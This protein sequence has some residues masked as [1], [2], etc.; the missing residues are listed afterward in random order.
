MAHYGSGDDYFGGNFSHT[1]C[2]LSIGTTWEGCQKR[3]KSEFAVVQQD[4]RALVEALYDKAWQN[5]KTDPTV[6]ASRM[7]AGALKAL[8]VLPNA[9]LNGYRTT[10]PSWFLLPVFQV[11]CLLVF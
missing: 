6:I 9:I 7:I 5:I 2:G 8:Q 4:E 10:A 1:L 3:Y 11:S